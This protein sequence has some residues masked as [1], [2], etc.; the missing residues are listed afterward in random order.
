MNIKTLITGAALIAAS[1]TTNAAV[2]FGEDLGWYTS[3][4]STNADAAFAGFQAALINVGVE[5]FE[6][7]SNG[8][9]APLLVDFGV[10][11]TA[12]LTG[13]DQVTNGNYPGGPSRRAHSGVNYWETNTSSFTINFSQSI[14]AFGFYGIDIGDFNGQVTLNTSGGSAS[15][16]NIPHSQGSVANG[17]LLYWGV[18]DTANT[19]TSITFSNTG[20]GADFFGFDDF[21]IGSVQQVRP[22]PAPAAVALFGLGLAGLGMSRRRKA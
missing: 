3:N 5:D 4:T 12:T 22:V 15:T 14:A 16:Y 11:G 17:S 7:F 18:I 8:A 2:Y 10:A 20:S 19:F 13:G 6:S 1:A 9:S 21:T